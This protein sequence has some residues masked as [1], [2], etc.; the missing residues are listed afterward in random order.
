MLWRTHQGSVVE[1]A[2]ALCLVNDVAGRLGARLQLIQLRAP[3][4]FG[5]SEL[6]YLYAEVVGRQWLHYII[7]AVVAVHE[8]QDGLVDGAGDGKL[9]H[10]VLGDAHIREALVREHFEDSRWHFG[11]SGLRIVA[12]PEVS[13]AEC[14][15]GLTHIFY[16]IV[17]QCFSEIL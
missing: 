4:E 7:L 5:V 6:I 17:T 3:G 8:S 10:R 9:A 14:T 2:V 11:Q 1:S 16:Q 15:K 12:V 13:L